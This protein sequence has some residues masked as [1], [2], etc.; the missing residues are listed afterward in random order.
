MPIKPSEA[1]EMLNLIM[2]TKRE[3]DPIV[4]RK[5]LD[6]IAILSLPANLRKTA[7][8][9]HK[10]GKAT[11]ETISKITGREESYES[12]CLNQLVEMGYLEI[13]REEKEYYLI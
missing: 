8:A 2:G 12:N 7:M 3:Q 9:I 5:H 10:K 1:K 4:E 11:A 6:A 13:I